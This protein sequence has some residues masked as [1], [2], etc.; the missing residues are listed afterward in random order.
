MSIQAFPASALSYYVSEGGGSSN[1]VSWDDCSTKFVH[2]LRGV[3]ESMIIQ[4]A[5]ARN[6][7]G[8]SRPLH[9]QRGSSKGYEVRRHGQCGDG[10]AG[11]T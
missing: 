5:S 9:K 2:G 4:V 10:T 6:T 11:A 8:L 3:A 1:R 7:T